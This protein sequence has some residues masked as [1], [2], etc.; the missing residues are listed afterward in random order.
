MKVLI[1]GPSGSGKTYVSKA[2][3]LKGINAYED[4]DIKN[5][6]SWYDKN[7]N[8]VVAPGT[9]HE[10]LANHYSFLWS[11]RVLRRFLNAHQDAFVF[12]GS[13]NIFDVTNLF[14]RTFFLKIELKIQKERILHSSRETPLMDFDEGFQEWRYR[15]VKLVERTIG[16]K[17]GTGGTAGVDFLKRSLFKPLFPD[18]WAVR[19]RM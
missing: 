19:Y 3:K 17:L 11:K 18:L 2:W 6:S 10:A 12:G 8:K 9:A 7:G 15:H 16:A 1:F 14:D 5:L 13:G 4:R